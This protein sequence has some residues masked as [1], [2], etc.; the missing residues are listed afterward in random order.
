M[1]N[2]TQ[3]QTGS[4]GRARL[5]VGPEHTAQA[6]GSG[7]IDVFASPMMIALM[8]RA[9]VECLAAHLRAGEISL[10]THLDIAHRRASPLGATIEATAELIAV[11]GRVLTFRVEARDERGMIGDGRHTRAVVDEAR[12]RAKLAAGS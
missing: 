3:Y 9:A 10:G 4:V 7:T 11:D 8:E 6:V 1:T 12:F 2:P 5:V